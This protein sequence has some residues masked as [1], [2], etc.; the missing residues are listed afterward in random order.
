MA[1]IPFSDVGINL[2]YLTHGPQLAA[3]VF[4]RPGKSGSST[5]S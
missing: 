3:E 1:A 4:G 2:T 5:A